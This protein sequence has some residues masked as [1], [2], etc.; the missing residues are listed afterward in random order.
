MKLAAIDIGTNAVRLQISSVLNEQEQRTNTASEEANVKF[1]KLEYIRFPLRLGSNVFKNQKIT[2]KKIKKLSKL[3]RAF[4]ILLKLYK[5]DETMICATAAIREAENGKQIVKHI[6]DKLGL[7]IRII[8]GKDE[9]DMISKVIL[10]KLDDKNYLHI[11]VGG[12]STELNLYVNKEKVSSTSFKIGTV[13]I[14][15]GKI[16]PERWEKMEKWIID[17]VKSDYLPITAIGTGGSI[18]KIS[19]LLRENFSDQEVENKTIS[20]KSIKKVQQYLMRFTE[21]ERINKLMLNPDRADVIIPASKIYLSVMKWAKA[22]KIMVPEVGLKD[23]MI[24]VLYE[25]AQR[26]APPTGGA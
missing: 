10:N 25:G 8:T 9:A 23:G 4:K 26:I 1:K 20:F 5:V 16:K 24:Q 12:G 2:P 21:E 18:S 19:D 14:L 11:D 13:R 22:E 17:N 3:L 6:K 7:E 15:K